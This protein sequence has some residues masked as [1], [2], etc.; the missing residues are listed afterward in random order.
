VIILRTNCLLQRV[1]EGK[2]KGGIEVTKEEEEDVRSYWMA[3][4]TGGGTLI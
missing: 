3:L 2:I 4:R 1:T